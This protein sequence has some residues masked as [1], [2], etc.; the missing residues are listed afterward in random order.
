MV[1]ILKDS[2]TWAGS[3]LKQIGSHASSIPE[4][5]IAPGLQQMSSISGQVTSRLMPEQTGGSD[6][7]LSERLGMLRKALK[8]PADAPVKKAL[9]EAHSLLG[10]EAS[11]LASL[12]L[13]E[14]VD[15]LLEKLGVDLG[16]LERESSEVYEGEWKNGKQEGFGKKR[17]T[18]TGCMYE[19]Q[20]CT[21]RGLRGGIRM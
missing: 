3:G 10:G 19:G 16:A 1:T 17:Y 15:A 20:V 4:T 21:V 9:E 7:E 14:R 12:S 2:A 18:A 8:L 6:S 11:G 13:A 5:V